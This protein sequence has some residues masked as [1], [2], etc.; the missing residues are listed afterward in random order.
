[1][2][3]YRPPGVAQGPPPAPAECPAT[4]PAAATPQANGF[5]RWPNQPWGPS[6]WPNPPRGP[7]TMPPVAPGAA[8]PPVALVEL[9]AAYVPF[10]VYTQIFRPGELP[11]P[12]TI[13]PELLRT[14]PLYRWPP[15]T[16]GRV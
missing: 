10:Q 6:P 13:F 1:M 11:A 12:G 15:S 16:D 4:K 2:R 5:G 7:A 3:R 9:A 8:P 14:P